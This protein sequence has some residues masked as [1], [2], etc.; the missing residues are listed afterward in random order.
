M[1]QLMIMMMSEVNIC[2]PDLKLAVF[3]EQ[4]EPFEG[5]IF[6]LEINCKVNMEFSLLTETDW[7]TAN[8]QKYKLGE[9]FWLTRIIE[10]SFLSESEK[11]S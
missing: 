9:A 7:I 6:K 2:H 5:V 1:I 8:Q 4:D 10:K 3:N 11:T